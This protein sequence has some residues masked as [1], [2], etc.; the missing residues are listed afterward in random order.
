MAKVKQMIFGV[1]GLL[2]FFNQANAQFPYGDQWYDNPLG[3]KPLEL[4]TAMGF[5]VPAVAVGTC[6]L[7]TKKDPNLKDR[8]SIYNE[9]GLS[10]GYKY[11]YT[12]MP[13]NNTGINFQLRKFMSMGIEWDIY[14][15]RDEFNQTTGFA[16]RPFARF[17]PINKEKWRLYFE[18]GGGFIYLLN[19]FPLP[20]DR[21]NRLGTQW[22]GTTKYGI[23][24]EINVTKSMAILF[25]VRH[26]HISNGNTKG[27]DRNP[28]HD[29]NG[30]FLGLSLKL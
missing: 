23:G 9:T 3:F 20:T 1:I 22:N 6:L 15:P 16:I 10:W 2:I 19:E 26:L 27:V 28:S 30:F 14:L 5:L 8:L 25:G 17:Y 29:S 12:F 24:S 4:H 18:S 11:P 13:Q 7:L 21:D